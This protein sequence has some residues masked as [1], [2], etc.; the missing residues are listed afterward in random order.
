MGIVVVLL[1]LAVLRGHISRASDDKAFK[2]FSQSTR[3]TGLGQYA[4]L[5]LFGP[6]VSRSNTSSNCGAN[7]DMITSNLPTLYP[8]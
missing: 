5:Q 6:I 4:S 8:T 7:F 2:S 3:S 1:K